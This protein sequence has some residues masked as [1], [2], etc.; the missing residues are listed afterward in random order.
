MNRKDRRAGRTQSGPR[1]PDGGELFALA[2]RHHQA[3]A[4]LEAEELYRQVLAGDR[5]HF[6]SLHYLGIIA[7]QRGQPQ[8]AIEPIGRAL[9]V[10]GGVPDCHYNMAFALQALGRIDEAKEAL[11]RTRVLHPD[12]SL[13]HVEN[14]TVYADP[15]DR[16]RFLEGLRRAGLEK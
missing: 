1:A 10:N 5:K 12:L 8:A 3:G 13:A 2:V 6:A 9:A 7:L 16:S 14:D 4:L 11:A 15:A